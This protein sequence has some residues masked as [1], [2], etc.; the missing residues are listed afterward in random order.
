LK[1]YVADVCTLF[2]SALKRADVSR[3]RHKLTRNRL[4]IRDTLNF[5]HFLWASRND[6]FI[7][8]F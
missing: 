7:Y 3:Q 6:A 5:V 4:S 2:R 1:I 8:F